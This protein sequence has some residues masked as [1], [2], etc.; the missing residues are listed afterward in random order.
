MTQDASCTIFLDGRPL[1]ATPGRPLIDFLKEQGTELPHICYH[2]SLGAL[3]TCDVCWV[4]VAGELKRAC[5]LETEDGLRVSMAA[6]MAREAQHEA[7]GV[8][9]AYRMLKDE[10]LWSSLM[11]LIDG[12]KVFADRMGQE[13]EKPITRFTGKPTEN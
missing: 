1:R 10:K 12:L 5:T 7:P 4:E 11:P 2:P 6:S 3:Q 9:G 13:P 8:T